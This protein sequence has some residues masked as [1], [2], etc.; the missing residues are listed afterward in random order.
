MQKFSYN[1]TQLVNRA[2]NECEDIKSMFF[3][4]KYKVNEVVL[5]KHIWADRDRIS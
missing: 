1:C 5:V 4:T 2:F 3:E